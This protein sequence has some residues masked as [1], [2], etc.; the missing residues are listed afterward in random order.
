[1]SNYAWKLSNKL[2][3][4]YLEDKALLTKIVDVEGSRLKFEK[5]VMATYFSPGGKAIAWQVSFNMAEWDR[6]ARAIGMEIK[7]RAPKSPKKT[8]ASAKVKAKPALTKTTRSKAAAKKAEPAPAKTAAKKSAPAKPAVKTPKMQAATK[9]APV[10]ATKAEPKKPATAKT[11]SPKAAQGKASQTKAVPAQTAP[12]KGAR[13]RAAKPDPAKTTPAS[14]R[15]AGESTTAKP[16]R[17]SKSGQQAA[18]TSPRK[19][20]NART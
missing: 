7:E 10:K 2:G 6:V 18:V 15:G 11:A 3:V 16:S 5:A 1:M 19:P 13:S 20:R 9:A 14:A 8:S 12:A 4:A 17:V